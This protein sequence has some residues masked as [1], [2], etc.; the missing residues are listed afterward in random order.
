MMVSWDF[1]SKKNSLFFA[2]ISITVV[3][4]SI[5]GY[6][7]TPA[8][9]TSNSQTPLDPTV[10]IKEDQVSNVFRDMV[11]VQRKAKEKASKFL[12]STFTSFF[13]SVALLLHCLCT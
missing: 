3:S 9:N 8:A 13:A 12:F 6:A 5:A 10:Q 2:L 7:Q 11:V 1:F 4:I